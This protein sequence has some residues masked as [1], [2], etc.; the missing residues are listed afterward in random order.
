MP[1]LRVTVETDQE[2]AAR[3]REWHERVPAMYFLDNSAVS[4]IKAHVAKGG[5]TGSIL[6][7]W[8]E[9]IIHPHRA[10]YLLTL[11][12]KASNV[13][14]PYLKEELIAEAQRD[15][16]ALVT[17]FGKE[18]AFEPISFM[19]SM[20]EQLRGQLPETMGREYHA[21]LNFVASSGVHIPISPKNRLAKAR[22]F[23]AKAQESEISAG[24]PVVLV[25]LSRIYGGE[26]A[27]AVLKLR[28][29]PTHFSSSNALGD[30]QTP[31]RIAR[32]LHGLQ[33]GGHPIRGELITCDHGLRK[34]FQAFPTSVAGL[35]I[36]V[37]GVTEK[38]TLRPQWGLLFPG[39]FDLSN[40]RLKEEA[41]E[42]LNLIGVR[43]SDG[44]P[45]P[46]NVS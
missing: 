2:T 39:L 45:L 32:L 13:N 9:Q 16:T 26:A 46:P 7:A 43:W 38:F 37:E 15:L 6:S 17:F 20:L 24:H 21:F 27:C 3:L 40:Q 4:K 5:A 42:V 31:M 33:E 41:Q 34:L 11:L 36:D 35:I 19:L 28:K 18:I 10:T 8:K 29:D 44:L 25:A 30:I 1:Q 23:V 12:E 14:K 22:A